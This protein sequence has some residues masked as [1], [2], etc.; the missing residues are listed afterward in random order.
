MILAADVGATKTALGL[1]DEAGLALRAVREERYRNDGFDAFEAILDRFLDSA[2]RP[3]LAVA[4]FGVAGP[5]I[6]NRV[7]FLNVPWALD[8]AALAERLGLERVV[9]LNDLA[10]A[11]YGMIHL[12]PE[13][14]V[15]LAPGAGP[16]RRGNVAVIAA[17]TGLGEAFLYWDGAAHHPI[18]TEGGHGDFAPTSDVE[19]ALLEYL[20]D[21][22]GGHVSYER[23]LSGSGVI[24]IYEFLRDTGRGEE[25]PA[26]R[27]RLRGAAGGGDPAPVI[28]AAGLAGEFPLCVR[29]LELFA[30]IY[31]AEAG[32]LALKGLTLGGVYVGGGIAPKI[33][34]KL[35]D[36]AFVRAFCAKGRRAA[37]LRD[38][39]IVVA[40]D[41]DAGRIGAAYFARR[42]ARFP[43]VT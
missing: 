4:C 25:P 14:L 20:R 23:V 38:I 13:R 5:V 33:L 39:R 16:G 24:N 27:E 8:A 3:C 29:A 43:S 18:A 15:E 17:G 11:A 12:P 34:A 2:G 32:N 42:T 9:L 40:T 10:A 21:R 36:G 30:S 37:L 26:L 22:F 41:P 1:Y 35:T 19:A 31:G 7:E 6:E 28:S